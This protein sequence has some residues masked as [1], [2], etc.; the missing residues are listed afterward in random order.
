MAWLAGVA[1]TIGRPTAVV[2]GAYRH[3]SVVLKD[4]VDAIPA[5]PDLRDREAGQVDLV[6]AAVEREA[7]VVVG[8]NARYWRTGLGHSRLCCHGRGACS[9]ASR[10]RRGVA[11]ET[12][13]AVANAMPSPPEKQMTA[14]AMEPPLSQA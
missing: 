4:L 11:S 9:D 7:V 8:R 13:D 10:R 2:T 14:G 12:R 6:R 1:F 5:V 3:D